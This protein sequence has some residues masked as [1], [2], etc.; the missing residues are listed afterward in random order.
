MEI[1]KPRSRL[2]RTCSESVSIHG[3]WSRWANKKRS[4]QQRK[5]R[6]GWPKE[7]NVWAMRR[8]GLCRCNHC[9]R[10]RNTGRRRWLRLS[11]RAGSC[12]ARDGGSLALLPY[13]IPLPRPSKAIGPTLILSSP[14]FLRNWRPIFRGRLCVPSWPTKEG[15]CL[16]LS[17]AVLWIGYIYHIYYG[18]IFL[19]N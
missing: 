17:L 4:D 3:H 1:P 12:R 19:F 8:R 14:R 13:S 15:T 16:P 18:F 9:R 6:K 7:K 5:P 11:P 2:R 10:R